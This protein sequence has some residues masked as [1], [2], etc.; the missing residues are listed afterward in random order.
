MAYVSLMP[1]TRIWNFGALGS[2]IQPTEIIFII[3]FFYSLLAFYPTWQALYN[4]WSL[5]L[6]LYALANVAS[7]INSMEWSSILES[8]GRVYLCLLFFVT[9]YCL[10]KQDASYWVQQLGKAIVGGSV[11]MVMFCIIGYVAIWFGISNPT[12]HL[13]NDYPYLGTIG[14]LAGFT[15]GPGMLVFVLMPG[16]FWVWNEYRQKSRGIS[17]PILLGSVLLLTFAKELL[18]VVLGLFIIESQYFKLTKQIFIGIVGAIAFIYWM[19]T[20]TVMLRKPD[21]THAHLYETEYVGDAILAQGNEFNLVETCYLALKQANWQVGLDHFWLGVG[22]GRSNQYLEGLKSEGLYP[23]HL[24]N[25][26][27]HSTWMG[28]FSE[29]GILGLCALLWLSVV[30]IRHIYLTRVNWQSNPLARVM[31]VFL[32]L[33]LIA[34]ISVDMM[35]F[36]QLWVALGIVVAASIGDQHKRSVIGF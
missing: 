24:P 23:A 27:P 12:V 19:G 18:L 11:A 2:H 8:L 3:L 20:H 22:P 29:T 26:D 21:V 36:R 13:F 30:A 16:F 14:R 9:L 6:S 5:P 35:N 4:K 10:Q 25:Y 31:V 32:F 1:F 7:A 34:S 33:L 17:L 15:S 28:A